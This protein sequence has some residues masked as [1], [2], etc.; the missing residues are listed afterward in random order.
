MLVRRSQRNK[1]SR[2]VELPHACSCCFAE[3]NVAIT[4]G[5]S[6][7]NPLTRT[8]VQDWS[9]P[10]PATPALAS[11]QMTVVQTLPAPATTIVAHQN[12]SSSTTTYQFTLG[13][14]VP[15]APHCR[16]V[17]ASPAVSRV[18]SP[19]ADRGAEAR[20]TLDMMD[21]SGNRVGGGT[22]NVSMASGAPEQIANF[23]TS[24]ADGRHRT[25]SFDMP[26]ANGDPIE[27]LLIRRV[28]PLPA[29]TEYR[30][31]V[32]CPNH[33]GSLTA[34]QSPFNSISYQTLTC[35]PGQTMTLTV[36]LDLPPTSAAY[37]VPTS[38]YQW[39]IIGAP[40]PRPRPKNIRAIR[41]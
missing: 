18:L 38:T 15:T 9:A 28:G 34:P 3:S 31:N 7:T 33:G 14:R 23:T 19:R 30:Y 16:C 40:S 29:S 39:S 1:P 2:P 20:V 10:P 24:S 26:D 21:F 17:R 35:T 41:I 22:T 37:I 5:A 4:F 6:S 25:F 11:Y 12:L 27:Y 13:K 8:V 36:G 32:S